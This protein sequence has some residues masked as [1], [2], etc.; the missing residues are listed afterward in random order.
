[1]SYLTCAVQQLCKSNDEESSALTGEKGQSRGVL[2]KAV[3]FA[4]DQAM[5][6]GTEKRLQN[7][8]EK[9]EQSG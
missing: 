9:S 6:A 7:I 5:V 3:K 2:I 1:M 4:D 8:M